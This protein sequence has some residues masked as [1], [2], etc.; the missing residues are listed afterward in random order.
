MAKEPLLTPRE[1]ATYLKLHVGTLAKWRC[2]GKGPRYRTLE[3]GQ[4][5]YDQ[6]DL[7]AWAGA[8][9]GRLPGQLSLV[10]GA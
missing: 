2:Q 3:T 4:I 8:P 9:K 6:A 7:D 10:R 5:R 1:A